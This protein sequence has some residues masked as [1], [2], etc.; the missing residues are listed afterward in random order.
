MV[1]ET[2]GGIYCPLSPRDPQNRLESLLK[3]TESRHVLVHHL[4]RTKFE[5]NVILIDI[6][7]VLMNRN[8]ENNIEIHRLSGVKVEPNDIAYVIFTSGSTGTPKA[9]CDLAHLCCQ[10]FF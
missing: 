5:N 9:V 2:S 6:D 3:Q 7:A 8:V 1:I 4:T 10:C